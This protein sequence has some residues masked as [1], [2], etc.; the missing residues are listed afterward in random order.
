[1]AVVHRGLHEP[2]GLPGV[3]HIHVERGD[4]PERREELLEFRPDAAVDM[5]AMTAGDASAVTAVL[6]PSIPLVAAS[7]IDVYRVC[8]SID[9]GVVTDSVPLAEDAPLREGPSPDRDYVSPGWDYEPEEY[10]KLEVERIYLEHGAVVCRLPM[11][12]GEHDYK[13]R[14]EFV[15]R[16][17]RAGRRRI[18]V[19]PGTFLCSRAYAPE[20]ARGLRLAVESGLEGEIFNLAESDSATIGLRV[21]EILAAAGHEAELV[22]VADDLLP[23]DLQLTAEIPQ[24]WLVSSAKAR[25]RLNWIHAPWRDCA[26]KSVAWHLANPPRS[27]D[28]DPAFSVDETALQSTDG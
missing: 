17:V 18:P 15:L 8:S 24:P 26:R 19:G 10:E 21:E 1:M 23:E 3:P 28:V 12:Y 2:E 25:E 13:R 11:V 27:G 6:D 5:A 9:E 20:V 22:R 14:E 16:R 7:S 4:L